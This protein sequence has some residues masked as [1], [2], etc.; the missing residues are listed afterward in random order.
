M[1]GIAMK[2]VFKGWII[3]KFMVIGGIKK[4]KINSWIPEDFY[5]RKSGNIVIELSKKVIFFMFALVVEG[6]ICKCLSASGENLDATWRSLGRA[7]VGDFPDGAV[8][9]TFL[10]SFE[11]F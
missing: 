3:F 6:K 2:N 4:T 9:N 11:L 1:D 10:S 8:T 7:S 5:K